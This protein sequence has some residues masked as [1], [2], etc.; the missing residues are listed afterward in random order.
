LFY[1]DENNDAFFCNSDLYILGCERKILKHL[2]V[3]VAL[4]GVWGDRGD[5]VG[6]PCWKSGVA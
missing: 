5:H 4:K 1:K 3:Y 6:K 2:G